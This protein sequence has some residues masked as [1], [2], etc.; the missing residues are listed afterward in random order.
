MPA[1]LDLINKFNQQIACGEIRSI[2]EIDGF[3]EKAR[4]LAAC[5]NLY[6]QKNEYSEYFT[7]DISYDIFEQG[8]CPKSQEDIADKYQSYFS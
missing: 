3:L 1:K 5:I 2:K 6:L 8:F 4:S 7:K